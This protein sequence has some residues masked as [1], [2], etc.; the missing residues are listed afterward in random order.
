MNIKDKIAK[1]LALSTSPVT[2]EAESALLKARELMAKYKIDEKILP[3]LTA[4]E[5]IRKPAGYTCVPEKGM[6]KLK[7][8]DVIFSNFCCKM[9]TARYPRKKTIEIYIY[10]FVHDVDVAIEAFRYAVQ[11]VE[12][13]T[14]E[15]KVDIHKAI[16]ST[17]WRLTEQY[18]NTYA[19]SFSEGLRVSFASQDT[20][21][22]GLAVVIP[23]AVNNEVSKLRCRSCVT[24]SIVN[25]P[26][27]E[28][29]KAVGYQDGLNY[30]HKK[31]LPAGQE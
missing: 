3:N 18:I 16:H 30:R 17:D 12:Y 21:D 4:Q 14:E 10:G 29:L 15:L 31:P 7:L 24:T 9:V 20:A 23:E 1:L 13:S 11:F 2:A 27:S 6:W 19:N 8:A 22:W 25:T 28:N 5:V 26:L